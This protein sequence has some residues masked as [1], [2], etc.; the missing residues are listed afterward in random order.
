M[1]WHHKFASGEST[2]VGWIDLGDCTP[3]DAEVLAKE[4]CAERA[5]EYHWSEHY[6]GIDYE[7]VEFPPLE[8]LEA[9]AKKY[10]AQTEA[11]NR[12]AEELRKMIEDFRGKG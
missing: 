11:A 3:K 1:K 2:E 9:L 6:R 12:R 7:I 8:V 10:R 4:E 5:R